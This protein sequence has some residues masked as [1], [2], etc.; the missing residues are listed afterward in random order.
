MKSLLVSKAGLIPRSLAFPFP[1]P[2]VIHP[3]APLLSK[4]N[5]L[6]PVLDVRFIFVISF[7]YIFK[8]PLK[9]KAVLLPRYA[10]SC[11]L[12]LFLCLCSSVNMLLVIVDIL[13]VTV[14]DFLAV[15]SQEKIVCMYLYLLNYSKMWGIDFLK[16]K[17]LVSLLLQRP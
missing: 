10:G 7:I 6:Q 2:T 8:V 4:C 15:R 13:K 11:T 14:I 12:K 17:Y 9:K 16:H 1:C 3:H 5:D